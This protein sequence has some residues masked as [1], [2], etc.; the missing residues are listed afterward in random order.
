M[1]GSLY[2]CSTQMIRLIYLHAVTFSFKLQY[3]FL[4]KLNYICLILSPIWKDYFSYI[5][6]WQNYWFRALNVHCIK[7]SYPVK[8]DNQTCW[9]KYV[10]HYCYLTLLMQC[11]NL[12]TYS[13]KYWNKCFVNVME[14]MGLSENRS[15][16]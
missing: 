15:E 8:A 13:W 16:N 6:E 4:F 3:F 2:I 9:D 7:C 1:E 14:L 5:S 12:I 11:S 10:Q